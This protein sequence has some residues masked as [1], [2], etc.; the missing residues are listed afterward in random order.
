M[1]RVHDVH[2]YPGVLLLMALG[3]LV[4]ISVQCG[5]WPSCGLLDRVHDDCHL[6]AVEAHVMWLGTV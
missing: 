2:G 1:G 3:A 5:G 4:G 6:L